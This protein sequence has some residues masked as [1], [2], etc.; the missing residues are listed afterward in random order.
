MKG[1]VEKK[2]LGIR[3]EFQNA[4][5]NERMSFYAG[6]ITRNTVIRTIQRI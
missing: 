2:Q 1:T 5:T 4:T 6:R 3:I